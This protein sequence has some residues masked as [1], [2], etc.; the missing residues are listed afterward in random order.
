RSQ[1][2]HGTSEPAR[3]AELTEPRSVGAA[4][5][6]RSPRP[7]SAIENDGQRKR[8][9]SSPPKAIVGAMPTDPFI[10]SAPSNATPPDG[11]SGTGAGEGSR[12]LGGAGGRG[13]LGASSLGR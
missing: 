7:S 13:E 12:G 2:R 5:A 10:P 3:S 4:D 8:R 9:E 11:A 1:R 6:G